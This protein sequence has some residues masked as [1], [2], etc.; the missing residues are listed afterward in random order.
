MA[1]SQSDIKLVS[2]VFAPLTACGLARLSTRDTLKEKTTDHTDDLVS[3]S[4]KSVLSV[5]RFSAQTGM[6]VPL[7]TNVCSTDHNGVE[8]QLDLRID[9]VHRHSR[10]VVGAERVSGQH[11]GIEQIALWVVGPVVAD[12]DRIR[13]V[14]A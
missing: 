13:H 3:R 2:M 6:S 10:P 14:L 8:C 12:R 5:V 9:V 7:V 1:I 4:V 11:L